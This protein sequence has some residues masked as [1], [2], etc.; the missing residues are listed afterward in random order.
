MPNNIKNRI[1]IIGTEEQVKSVVERFSTY[2]ESKQY[3]DCNGSL[4]FKHSETENYGWL[5]QNTNIFTLPDR[6][7]QTIGVPDGYV[8][9]MKKEWT[10]FPDFEKVIIPP[11]DK[12]YKD[13]PS[14]EIARNSPNWWYTWNVENWGTKWNAYSCEKIAENIF[15][16]ET[17]WRGVPYLVHQI[18]QNTPDIK[19]IYKYASEDTGYNVGL[20]VFDGV[21]YIKTVI[22]NGSKEAYDLAFELRPEDKQ[23]YVLVGESYEFKDHGDVT[24]KNLLV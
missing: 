15:D 20:Y 24:Q 21:T 3:A 5:N 12:A 1:E 10:R 8:P 13:L 9:H 7:I 22:Y 6:V 14:Q 18:A 19:I 16:F 17:A 11:N 4:T 23:N 2:Y